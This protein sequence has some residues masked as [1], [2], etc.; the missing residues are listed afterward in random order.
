M[1]KQ[2]Q[3]YLLAGRKSNRDTLL[4]I[5][6]TVFR[7]NNLSSPVIAYIGTANGDDEGFFKRMA[8]PLIAAGADKVNHALIAPYRADVKKAQAILDSSDIVFVSGG[9]VYE[10]MRVLKEK[11]MIDFL[12]RLYELGKP[13]FGSSAGSIMLAKN[14][15]NW[16]DPDDDSTAKL[17]S[18]LGIAPIICDTHDEQD[19][20][21]ELKMAL[22]LAT[23]GQKGYGIVSATAIKVY[24]DI[25]VEALGGAV[26]QFIR[27]GDKVV[28]LPDIMP[29]L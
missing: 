17:F 7:E 27:R 22:R 25:E 9:D 5:L 28:R 2:K 18:C 12:H 10:G 1:S 4:S 20:W 23:D 8:E 26:H 15:V 29:A 24:P 3:S 14:W 13:F 6:Q 16:S 11:R 21:E 19:D